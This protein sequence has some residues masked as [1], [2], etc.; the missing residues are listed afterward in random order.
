MEGCKHTDLTSIRFLLIVAQI[1]D[2]KTQVV[3]FFLAFPHTDL[4]V[5]VYTELSKDTDLEGKGGNSL[6]YVLRFSKSLYGLKQGSHN[7]YNNLKKALLGKGCMESISAPCVFVSKD[8]IILIHV[9]QNF[10]LSKD[11]LPM[12]TFFQS[13]KDSNNT[14][15]LTEE[16]TLENHIGINIAKVPDRK[17]LECLSCS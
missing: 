14:F 1:L 10:V 6:H 12:K 2:L 5:P 7:W 8:M 16:G 15:D 9:E 4:G 13:L 3:D 11:E 17:A